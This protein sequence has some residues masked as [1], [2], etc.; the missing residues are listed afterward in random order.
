MRYI[1]ASISYSEIAKNW[2]AA[3]RSVFELRRPIKPL[4]EVMKHFIQLHHLRTSVWAY[5][6]EAV[7]NDA[8]VSIVSPGYRLRTGGYAGLHTPDVSLW[9]VIHTATDVDSNKLSTRTGRTTTA[10][11][12]KRRF[13]DAICSWNFFGI[14]PEELANDKYELLCLAHYDGP[15]DMNSIVEWLRNTIGMTPFMV[16]AHFCPF[17]RRSFESSPGEHH[18]SR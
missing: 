11:D 12:F 14:T 9:A 2:L 8:D 1:T 7:A 5:I 13:K 3:T 16:R 4:P 18:L 15:L 6:N 10:A 17:F